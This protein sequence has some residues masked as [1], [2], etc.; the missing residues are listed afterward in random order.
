M[1][2][3][4]PFANVTLWLNRMAADTA[5]EQTLTLHSALADWSGVPS[6]AGAVLV[7]DVYPLKNNA[8]AQQQAVY[9]FP[10]AAQFVASVSNDTIAVRCDV[11]S[12][13]SL[14]EDRYVFTV[15]ARLPDD[16]LVLLADGQLLMRHTPTNKQDYN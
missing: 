11:V 15:T 7:M 5:S 4:Q 3:P 16:T 14:L 13:S 9:G 6:L 2:Q 8:S 10:S 12:V 1:N